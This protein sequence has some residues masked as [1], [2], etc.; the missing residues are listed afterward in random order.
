MRA[1]A[2]RRPLAAL[3]ALSLSALTG[4]AAAAEP[5]PLLTGW[6]APSGVVIGASLHPSPRSNGLV[7][8]VEQS[9]VYQTGPRASWWGGLYAEG[10]RDFGA[11]WTRFSFGPELGY[12]ALGVDGGILIALR[13]RAEAGVQ[14]RVLLTM[15][16]LAAYGRA[17]ALMGGEPLGFY[18]TGLLIKWPWS[19]GVPKNAEIRRKKA[20][21]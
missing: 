12:G 18:E 13:D 19:F 4:H 20:D 6:Y 14:G 1:L 5:R 16:Y 3:A 17:G 10:L 11:S 9:L 15:G 7:L 2:L 8:G 21:R